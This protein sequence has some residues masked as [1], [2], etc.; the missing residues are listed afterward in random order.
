M[1]TKLVDGNLKIMIDAETQAQLKANIADADVNT[2]SDGYM[3]DVFEHL[4]CNSEF[5]WI[6]PVLAGAL[7]DAPMLGVFGDAVG[8]ADASATNDYSRGRCVGHWNSE[9]GELLYWYE[10]VISAYAYMSYQVKSPVQ[11]LTNNGYVIFQGVN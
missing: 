11:D 6:E 10:P 9:S 7:T 5:Q 2:D 1:R 3:Y 4:I 8:F